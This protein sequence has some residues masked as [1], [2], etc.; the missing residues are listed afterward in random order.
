MLLDKETWEQF[1][2]G[3][4]IYDCVISRKDRYLFVLV[5]D[6]NSVHM[7]PAPKTKFLFVSA[8]CTMENRCYSQEC[9]HFGSTHA[10]VSDATGFRQWVAVDM[11]GQVFSYDSNRDGIEKTNINNRWNNNTRGAGITNIKRVNNEIYA[12]ALDRF[13]WHREGT[14]KWEEL[15]GLERP[16]ERIKKTGGVL[17]YGFHDLSAFSRDDMYAVGGHWDVWHFDG[18]AWSRI[19][20]PS[21]ESL[22]TVCCAGN[23]QVYISGYEGSLWSGRNH[24]WKK[25]L[26]GDYTLPFKDS[27]WF[28]G[29]MWFGMDYG[30]YMLENEKLIQVEFPDE[31][32]G[33][34]VMSGSIDISL[35]GQYMLTSGVCGAALYDGENWEPLWNTSFF[36]PNFDTYDEDE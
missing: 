31:I 14:E 17:N 34:G 4:S 5:E 22:Y 15:S 30:L 28:G 20:F 6:T 27:V 18:D 19:D 13:I 7:D 24:T 25:L 11:H 9:S 16:Q 29:K 21:N 35:D 32:F 1:V 2:S 33:L 8:D 26:D 23:G 3:Y 10:S 12:L 36:D